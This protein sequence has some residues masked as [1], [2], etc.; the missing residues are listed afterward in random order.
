[1]MNG[2]DLSRQ[3]F[4]FA[5]ENTDKVSGNHAAL[6][7]WAIELNNRLGWVSKFGLPSEVA[8]TA[9]GIRSYKTYSKIFD[10]LVEWGFFQVHQKSK[11]QYTSNVIALVIFTE[12]IPKQYQSIGQ[13]ITNAV[14]EHSSST[15]GINK[16]INLET[17]K[18]INLKQ[19]VDAESVCFEEEALEEKKEAKK[20]PPKVA[21]KSPPTLHTKIKELIE[22]KN[23]G[24]YWQGKDGKACKSLIAK[25]KFRWQNKHGSEATDEEVFGSVSWLIKNLPE[26]YRDKWDAVTLESKFEVIVKQISEAG[27]YGN[28]K[29]KQVN[30]NN[31]GPINPNRYS[32]VV[33]RINEREQERRQRTNIEE[34]DEVSV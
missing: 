11:N 26:W 22:S 24:Y 2:Y 17:N 31:V 7:W 23:P 30:S 33:E 3:W 18:P 13:S 1:M 28:G 8:M 34:V 20:S 5:F 21:P 25:I 4:D 29:S 9:C 19:D 10:D 27:K 32:K 14:Y 6:Y 15:V 12:A 16:H